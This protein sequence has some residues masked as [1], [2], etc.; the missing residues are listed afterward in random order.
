MLILVVLLALASYGRRWPVLHLHRW[1]DKE[2]W[3]HLISLLLRARRRPAATVLQLIGLSTPAA[4]S[5]WCAHL[6]QSTAACADRQLL[7]SIGAVHL[8]AALTRCAMI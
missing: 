4:R 3:Q 5:C 1:S 8:P 6:E 2:T 7:L